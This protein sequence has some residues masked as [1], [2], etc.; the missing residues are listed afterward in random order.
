MGVTIV[1]CSLVNAAHKCQENHFHMKRSSPQVN[2]R[3]ILSASNCELLCAARSF[4]PFSTS[5]RIKSRIKSSCNI[6]QTP[7][8]SL[9][10]D[11]GIIMGYLEP[12]QSLSQVGNSRSCMIPPQSG[13]I[14]HT[15][16]SPLLLRGHV[17]AVFGRGL[18]CLS[19]F[20]IFQS[21]TF[22]FFHN[23]PSL[24]HPLLP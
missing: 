17:S 9:E 18:K 2:I 16:C 5:A 11:V 20:V 10:F 19:H 13:S 22:A 12:Q 7:C 15:N 23:F 3:K 4:N 6:S 24:E 21:L 14:H 8:L 1:K